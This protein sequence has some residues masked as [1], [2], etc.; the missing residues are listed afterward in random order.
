[1]AAQFT[2]VKGK[3]YK[4]VNWIDGEIRITTFSAAGRESDVR[5]EKTKSVVM[6]ALVDSAHAEAL[7]MN[8]ESVSRDEMMA[9]QAFRAFWSQSEFSVFDNALVAWEAMHAE[10]L[11]MN[12]LYGTMHRYAVLVASDEVKKTLI[13]QAHVEAL[14]IND[15]IDN[16]ANSCTDTDKQDA[17]NWLLQRV[18]T[19]AAKDACEFL[20]I[21]GAYYLRPIEGAE[22]PTTQ[23]EP[24]NQTV[25]RRSSLSHKIGLAFAGAALMF[26]GMTH[27]EAL[28]TYPVDASRL[29][30]EGAVT[31]SIDCDSKKVDVIDETTTAAFFSRQVKS[32]VWNICY[33][34]KGT[35]A[36]NYT[37]TMNNQVAAHNM[38]SNNSDRH[39]L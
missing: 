23:A 11:E 1:M 27:A 5:S 6:A 3:E 21:K 37:F 17:V 33:G 36:R 32:Q 4:V 18:G 31:V 26:S 38:V 39:P 16:L 29:S 35:I 13:E 15:F 9:N 20:G 30:L 10:A 34:V 25:A 7:E 2:F 12:K 8:A 19:T 24:S 22:A 28:P 14:A